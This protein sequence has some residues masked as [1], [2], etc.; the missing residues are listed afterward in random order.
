MSI[1]ARS[2][3]G[4]LRSLTVTSWPCWPNAMATVRPPIPAPAIRILKGG[5]ALRSSWIA[6]S[7]SC[8]G[9]VNDVALI[10]RDFFVYL[11]QQSYSHSTATAFPHNS[12]RN[13]TTHVSWV[14]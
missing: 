14:Q 10:L 2:A 4:L 3:R 7:V 9:I 13:R 6:M 1:D 5:S 12:C 11:P 8:S